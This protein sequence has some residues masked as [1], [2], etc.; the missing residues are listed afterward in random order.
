MRIG[1]ALPQFHHQAFEVARVAE[2]AR[3]AERAGAASLWVGDRNLAAVRPLVGYGGHGDTIP[4]ELNPAADP[5]VLLGIAAAVTERVLLG[6]HV[7]IAPLYPAVQLARALTTI[8]VISG[9]RVLPGF[10]LG[11]S[12]EEYEAAGRDFARRGALLD[13]LLDALDVIWTQDPAGYSGNLLSVPLHHAPLKPA[14][15]P[16][17]PVYLGALS[18]V[19]LR[20]VA[21]RADGWLPLCVVP[22]YVDAEG[23]IAQRASIDT[24]AREAG[25]QPADIDTVLRVNVA[26]GTGVAAVADAIRD[27]HDKTEIDHFMVDSMY[28]VESV[29]GAIAYAR[30]LLALLADMTDTQNALF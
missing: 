24:W 30:E 15:T 1:F 27:L 7:L 22:D 19:A 14:R 20:R 25:R 21:R 26:Q 8:D 4:P 23:L 16:R 11:W 5:F 17:P 6:S 29:D 13:E 10:G 18:T 9:G 2:F 28:E 3:E 12:P